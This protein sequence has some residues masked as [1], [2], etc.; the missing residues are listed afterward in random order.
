MT[1]LTMWAVFAVTAWFIGPPL[2][3]YI[4][5]HVS[6]VWLI[7]SL[8]FYS[9]ILP[10][11]MDLGLNLLSTAVAFWAISHSGSLFLAIWCFFLMQAL[12]V[13][14]PPVV[15]HQRNHGNA[16]Y[17]GT[18]NF[19]QARRRAETAIRALFAR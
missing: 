1:C 16:A 15:G 2:I 6:A 8:Y 4:I 14:I 7:R 11:L 13:L 9:S 3:L 5:V 17:R 19:E 18:D 12:F 10:A